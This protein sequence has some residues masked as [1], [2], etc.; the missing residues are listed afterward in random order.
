[1]SG[2]I[3]IVGA[4]LAGSRAAEAIREY[5]HAGPVLMLGAEQAWPYQRPALSKE[6]LRDERVTLPSLWLQPERFYS[7]QRIEVRRGVIATALSL[8]KQHVALSSGEAVSWDRLIIATGSSP[9]RLAVPGAHLPGVRSV[10]TWE[11]AVALREDL[12]PGSRIVV[13]G[14]GLLGLEVASAAKERG[15]HATVLE[16]GSALL[17]RSLGALAGAALTPFIEAMGVM[18]RL[19][20]QVERVLGATRV[21]GVL[22]TFGE[23]HAADLVVVALGAEPAI[24]WLAGSGLTLGDG[25]VVDE[26]GRTSAPGVFAAGD[27]ASPWSPSLGRRLRVESYGF[28]AQHGFSVGQNAVGAMEATFPNPSGSTELFGKRLQF[29]GEHQGDETCH[30]MGEPARGRFVAL[31]GRG[32]LLV[33]RV[34]LGQP[35]TFGVLKACLGQTMA[36]AFEILGEAKPVEAR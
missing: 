26:F 31:L 36:R 33:G 1:M 25:V 7:E 4:G 28:A 35:H 10:R 5:G 9:R 23:V 19:R 29:S 32:G 18:V 2:S 14:G 11:D 12:R 21:E 20:T 30:L 22:S 8:E 15:A 13:I 24:G 3:V 27:V 34:T 6:V 17:S 16:R